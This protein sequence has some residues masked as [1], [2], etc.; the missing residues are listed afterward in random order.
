M[1][2]PAALQGGDTATN[3]AIAREILSGCLGPRRDIVLVNAAAAL[4]AAGKAE[5]FREAIPV[6]ATSID[7]GAARA[8]VEAL[9]RF[10]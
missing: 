4:V 10:R 6:A 1:A 2:G 7:S 8:K 3:A 9:A 5:S